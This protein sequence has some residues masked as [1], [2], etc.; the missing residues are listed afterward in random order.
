M[1]MAE[2]RRI[3]HPTD[4]SPASRAA[5]KTAVRFAKSSGARLLV[6]H[7]LP[8][9]PVTGEDSYLS[10]KVWDDM[11]RGQ[12]EAAQR[13][14][15][16][17]VARAKAAGAR[18]SGT[19]LESGVTHERIVRFA[20]ARRADLIVMGTHGRTGLTRALLGSV[21]ARVLATARCPV[22]TVRGTARG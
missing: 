17:I 18:A 9:L 12:R 22:M 7:V 4:F 15:D 3:V 6:A 2:F 8:M 10:P 14:L 19:L 5:L 1:A 20:R 16:P 21:A 11:Y 13:Q